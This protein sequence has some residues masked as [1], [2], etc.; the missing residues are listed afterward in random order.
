MVPFAPQKTVVCVFPAF[1][2][3][4]AGPGPVEISG[5]SFSF[6]LNQ[7][8]LS[9][10][11]VRSYRFCNGFPLFPL[12]CLFFFSISVTLLPRSIREPPT[13]G[14]ISP[15]VTEAPF[16][17]PFSPSLSPPFLD[18]DLPLVLGAV[19]LPSLA[20]SSRS[21]RFLRWFSTLY[22]AWFLPFLA[23]AL[24]FLAFLS[25]S[26]STGLRMLTPFFRQRCLSAL[27]TFFPPREDSFLERHV[28]R[29]S[30]NLRLRS[31]WVLW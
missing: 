8:V 13:G 27:V 3:F 26:I 7:G 16:R 9:P 10:P 25:M 11:S 19:F 29:G 18:P 6:P 23:P 15:R 1:V 21:P 22:V 5:G 17:T 28:P 12:R 30:P 4:T 14:I 24:F 31:A 2:F 20:A